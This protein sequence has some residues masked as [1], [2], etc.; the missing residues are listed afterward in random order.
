MIRYNVILCR[1]TIKSK[2]LRSGALAAKF[3][4]RYR[5]IQHVFTQVIEPFVWDTLGSKVSTFGRFT[6]DESI[7]V[8]IGR[9]LPSRFGAGC[10]LPSEDWLWKRSSLSVTCQP[11]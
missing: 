2:K 11:L 7:P 1:I 6:G 9:Q 8:V 10:R 3:K 4:N 5:V